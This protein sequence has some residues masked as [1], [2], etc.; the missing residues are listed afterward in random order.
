MSTGVA[1]CRDRSS[2]ASPIAG[3]PPV[4]TSPMRAALAQAR[5]M[6]PTWPA[7]AMGCKTGGQLDEALRRQT[8]LLLGGDGAR[9]RV[10]LCPAPTSPA[11][12]PAADWSG[13]RPGAW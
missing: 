3:S 7:W 6:W 9:R 8:V 2:R 4:S 12:R 13:L 1:R 10:E 5:R 11:T